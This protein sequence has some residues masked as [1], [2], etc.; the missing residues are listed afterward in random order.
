MTRV[1]R[2]RWG[3]LLLL[4]AAFVIALSLLTGGSGPAQGARSMTGSAPAGTPESSR[5]DGALEDAI[6]S[7]EYALK[8][9]DSKSI[10]AARASL[11]RL[12]PP[13]G[14]PLAAKCASVLDALDRAAGAR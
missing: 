6:R 8:V 7:G 3:I 13:A 5:S 11:R 12:Q 2:W 9:G 1:R 14:S 10:H 4:A